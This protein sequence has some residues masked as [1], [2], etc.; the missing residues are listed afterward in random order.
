MEVTRGEVMTSV[1][2]ENRRK[3]QEEQTGPIKSCEFC[4]MA[5]KA[6]TTLYK[7]M[8]KQHP[9]E[10]SLKQIK[11]QMER[12]FQCKFCHCKFRY[13]NNLSSHMK[14]VHKNDMA[15]N[16]CNSD[17]SKKKLYRNFCKEEGCNESFP[18][19]D[20]LKQHLSS[21]HF[22]EMETAQMTFK[23]YCDFEDWRK[24]LERNTTR[25]MPRMK[26]PRA[27][28]GFSRLYKCMR[29]GIYTPTVCEENRKRRLKLEGSYKIGQHCP[30][31]LTVISYPNGVTKVKACLTHYGHEFN[32]KYTLGY[33]KNKSKRKRR[34]YVKPDY[35]VVYT[36]HMQQ[37]NDHEIVTSSLATQENLRDQ[38]KDLCG[39][40]QGL[41]TTTEVSEDN[42]AQIVMNLNSSV[43]LAGWK[44][45]QESEFVPVDVVHSVRE[46]EAHEQAPIHRIVTDTSR[47]SKNSRYEH[48]E[49]KPKIE[50]QEVVQEYLITE[51]PYEQYIVWA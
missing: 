24:G 33:N 3:V 51:T 13:K 35:S 28:G 34:E 19:V 12:Q 23:T 40:L 4:A 31:Q 15:L 8:L 45:T 46:I 43:A 25:F 14:K 37:E 38:A 11:K 36:D 27:D 21:K 5:F 47:Y 49:L 1:A 18:T 9:E 32:G 29:S 2:W 39:F 6:R 16:G 41:L 48:Q 17:D 44:P 10:W 50:Q 7:H 30:A 22:I 26:W 42:L 20:R